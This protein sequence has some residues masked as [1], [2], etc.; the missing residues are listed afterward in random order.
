S[1]PRRSPWSPRSV[2]AV[3]FVL[4]GCVGGVALSTAV[5]GDHLRFTD[6][7]VSHAHGELLG[8]LGFVTLGAL[9][10]LWPRAAGRPWA[11][12]ALGR[13][14]FWASLAGAVLIVLSLGV[15][16]V[17]EAAFAESARPF[18]DLLDA[19]RPWWI[20]RLVGGA[21]LF[22]GALHLAANL[23]RTRPLPRQLL[24]SPAPAPAPGAPARPR[25]L[26]W[27]AA[28]LFAG[29]LL[30]EAAAIARLS[31]MAS[32]VPAEEI[33]R[34][35]LPEFEDMAERW[36]RPFGSAFPEGPTPAAYARAL[37][38]GRD[39]YVREG[40]WH[41]HTRLVRPGP[42]E[43]CWGAPSWP[44]EYET[45]LDRPPLAGTRRLG[46]DLAREAGRHS[47]DWHAAHLRDPRLVARRS[48]MPA[49]PW[50]VGEDGEP[51]RDGLALI[52]YLQWL[53]SWAEESR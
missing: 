20:V 28:A 32:G 40:C 47:D 3:A 50:L 2:V 6:W 24:T 49:F 1:A 10:V 41:C 4:G 14:A 39:A 29:A 23:L 38:A 21:V 45:E 17:V 48:P 51:T 44:A 26:S 35:V 13:G 30:A 12:P 8:F 37:R 25:A 33:A 19:A 53:G 31:T 43:R 36:P 9:A 27:A 16:G 46:P 15:A 52:A 11:S 18:E 42:D 34:V 7:A 22:I 5:A